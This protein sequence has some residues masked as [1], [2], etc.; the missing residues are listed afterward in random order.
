[1]NDTVKDLPNS[2]TIDQ[3]VSLCINIIAVLK[4]VN[5]LRMYYVSFCTW[6]VWVEQQNHLYY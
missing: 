1:M 4:N 5:C 6:H 2:W 3:C